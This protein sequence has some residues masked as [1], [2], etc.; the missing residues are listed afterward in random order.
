MHRC[1]ERN[2]IK[3]LGLK[4]VGC[5][6]VRGHGPDGGNV[7]SVD[8]VDYIWQV[9]YKVGRIWIDKETGNEYRIAHY[10]TFESCCDTFSMQN[11]CHGALFDLNNKENDDNKDN[12]D[13]DDE[14][15]MGTLYLKNGG[16]KIDYNV[17]GRFVSAHEYT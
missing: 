8:S 16:K 2:T 6:S 17:C 11:F 9:A 5:E 14:N 3:S 13:N 4:P 15:R 10:P 1:T 12:E 7:D